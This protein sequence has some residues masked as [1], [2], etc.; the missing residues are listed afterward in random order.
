MVNNRIK[1]NA[2][3]IGNLFPSHIMIMI[4]RYNYAIQ[5]KND[6]LYVHHITLS[7]PKLQLGFPIATIRIYRTCPFERGAP[8]QLVHY[9]VYNIC[10]AGVGINV[11]FHLRHILQMIRVTQ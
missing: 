11:C 4:C 7:Y 1:F 10:T 8:Q 3:L 6:S 2:F 9:G 5:I